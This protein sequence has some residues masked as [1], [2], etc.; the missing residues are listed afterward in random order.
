MIRYITMWLILISYRTR[1]QRI[2]DSGNSTTSSGEGGG[3]NGYLKT[4]G[5]KRSVASS[6]SLSSNQLSSGTITDN[7]PDDDLKSVN[8]EEITSIGSTGDTEITS[9]KNGARDKNESISSHIN[10][11][12]DSMGYHVDVPYEDK[13]FANVRR[14]SNTVST[15][16][17]IIHYLTL[18]S[19]LLSLIIDHYKSQTLP[20]IRF[21][22]DWWAI[23]MRLCSVKENY[24]VSCALF[25]GRNN[26]KAKTCFSFH[27]TLA[28]SIFW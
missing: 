4:A 14:M 12:F 5:R 20:I 6:T 27:L 16:L 11:D 23:Y 1:E 9:V 18:Y 15:T 2:S 3:E 21:L 25:R 8:L 7:I 13:L 10:E 22:I 26:R 19:T 17:L 28:A 24:D